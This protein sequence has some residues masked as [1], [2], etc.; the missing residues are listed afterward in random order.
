MRGFS[1]VENAIEYKGFVGQFRY[2]PEDEALHGVVLGMRDVIHFQ[3][4]SVAELK[5]SLESSVD[6]YLRWCT[7]EGVAP[8]TL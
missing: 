3:G 7:E 6:E 2:E 5:Q 8:A 4:T 1:Q